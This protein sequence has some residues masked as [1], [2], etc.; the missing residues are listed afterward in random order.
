VCPGLE[1]LGKLRTRGIARARDAPGHR[2]F[3]SW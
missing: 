3:T 2:F 1:P